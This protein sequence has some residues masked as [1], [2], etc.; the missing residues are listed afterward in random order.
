MGM[1]K[2]DIYDPLVTLGDKTIS[3]HPDA[4]SSVE[5]YKVVATAYD[6][7]TGGIPAVLEKI[8]TGN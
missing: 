1:G 5:N 2:E 8:F 6:L 3:K 4:G 7:K